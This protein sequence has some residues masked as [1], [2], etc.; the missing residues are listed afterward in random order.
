M[1]RQVSD[2]SRGRKLKPGSFWSVKLSPRVADSVT[3]WQ[4]LDNLSW[5]T[6]STDEQGSVLV[7]C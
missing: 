3:A 5:K 4:A 1:V 7:I 2:L 6:R